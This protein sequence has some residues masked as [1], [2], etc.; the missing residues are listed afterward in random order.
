MEI[1]ALTQV[2]QTQD[3]PLSGDN[4]DRF[5]KYHASERENIAELGF[6]NASS[7]T[8]EKYEVNENILWLA[9][10]TTPGGVRL[11]MAVKKV[12]GC[13]YKLEETKG[14]GCGHC[15]LSSM[16]KTPTSISAQDQIKAMEAGIMEASK[17]LG[18]TPHSVELL[19]DGSSLNESEFSTDALHGICSLIAANENIKKFAIETRPEFLTSENVIPLLELLRND[20]KLEIYIGLET[21]DEIVLKTFFRKGFTVKQCQDALQKLTDSIPENLKHKLQISLYN[22]FGTPGLSTKQI[23]ASAIATVRQARL[24]EDQIGIDINIKLEPAVA[25]EGTDQALIAT[26][27]P[28]N[29]FSVAEVLAIAYADGDSECLKFGQR[30]DI[31]DFIKVSKVPHL[32]DPN[33]FSPFDFMIYNAVQR[34]NTDRDIDGFF[35]N[36]AI[37]LEHSQEFKEWER[38]VYGEEGASTISLAFSKFKEEHPDFQN[39]FYVRIQFQKKIWRILDQIEGTNMIFNQI[40]R[41][42]DK[43]S[44][45]IKE[46]LKRL[47]SESDLEVLQIKYLK[48]LTDTCQVEVVIK[49]EAGLPENI[50]IR[51]PL[52]SNVTE[53]T[54]VP[55]IYE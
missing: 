5:L 48:L 2:E 14:K 11:C 32:E 3:F 43:I 4:L 12:K 45:Q 6:G 55:F 29:Y 52:T 42:S 25:S 51:I 31:D 50:W 36:I 27:N 24:L 23:I 13:A 40:D 33:K 16:Y 18:Y 53:Y 8:A 15:A 35:A 41:S 34:Y 47:F 37:A 17:I 9:L 44:L 46:A 19:P 30:D 54:K 1:T 38:G 22:F 10:A 21:L 28:P 26:Y 7:D 20:Q 49:D 39:E